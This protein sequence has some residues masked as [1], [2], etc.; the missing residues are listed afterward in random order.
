MLTGDKAGTAKN[1][2]A[3]CYMLPNP[4]LDKDDPAVG[5]SR[6]L[7]LT[8]EEYPVLNTL[9]TAEVRLQT[10]AR[11]K[12]KLILQFESSDLSVRLKRR[13]QA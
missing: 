5:L 2:A 3:A 1:I 6:I 13:T 7:D 11:T 10:S 8:I 12:L 4:T 9:R